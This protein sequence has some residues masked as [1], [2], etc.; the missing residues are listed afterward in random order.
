V[1]GVPDTRAPA[2]HREQIG[3]VRFGRATAKGNSGLIFRA[4]RFLSNAGAAPRNKKR[5]RSIEKFPA[6]YL[7]FL[8]EKRRR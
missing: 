4:P 8:F 6:P 1:P 7:L 3:F 2:L 5:V